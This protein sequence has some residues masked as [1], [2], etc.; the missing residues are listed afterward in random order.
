MSKSVKKM[1][2]KEFE[3]EYSEAKNSYY[4]GNPIMTDDCFETLEKYFKL[5]FPNN[6]LHKK[7]GEIND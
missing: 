2:E 1:T 6:K 5:R 7:V 4:A 3:K